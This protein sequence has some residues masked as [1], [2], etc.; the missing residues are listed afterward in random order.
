M[1]KKTVKKAA[2]KK[3]MK[4]QFDLFVYRS[5]LASYSYDD[6]IFIFAEDPSGRATATINAKGEVEI[7]THKVDTNKAVKSYCIDFIQQ[8]GLV[9][10]PKNQLVKWTISAA[11]VAVDKTALKNALLAAAEKV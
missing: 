2:P 5:G 10:L 8:L 4:P 1:A 6:R 9:D 11:P 7:S 3:V